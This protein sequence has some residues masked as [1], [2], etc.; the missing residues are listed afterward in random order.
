MDIKQLRYFRMV[1]EEGQVTKAA[2]KL[3]MAQPP[4]SQQIKLI[5]E[6][7][8]LKLFDRHGR[9]LEL[10]SAGEV[11][12]QKAGQ[13]L[14][15]LE[16]TIVEVKETNEGITGTL[17]IGSNKSCFSSLTGPLHQLREQYPQLTYQLREGDTY[18]LAEC[19]RRREIEM[20][21][22]RLPIEREEFEMIPLSPE[23]YV[24]VTPAYWD[25]FPADTAEVEVEDLKDIPL[26][27]LHRISGMGQF[28]LIVDECRKHGF[29]PNVICECPDPT[30]L[31][32]LVAN[33]MGASIVPRSTLEAFSF[34]NI[35]SYE[36]RNADIEAEAAIIWHK[37]RYL[38]KASRRLLQLFEVNTDLEN[39]VYDQLFTI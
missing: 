34:S 17:Q 36:F 8:D 28:E 5:E 39:P 12:Y 35:R 31:L 29:D 2:K 27:L 7:L 21:V 16:E 1:A 3:H 4:L 26:M 19:I 38:T 9:K 14:N 25:V 18:F 11:L 20:A 22:V 33:G 32:S 13:I 15:E 23:P 6:E 37:D 24:L 30:M 10:T